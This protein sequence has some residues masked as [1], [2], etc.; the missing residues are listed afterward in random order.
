M[1]LRNTR[2]AKRTPEQQVALAV[3]IIEHRHH[4]DVLARSPDILGDRASMIGPIDLSRNVLRSWTDRV[5]RAYGITPFVGSMSPIL[6]A[7]LGDASASVTVAKYATADGYPMPST[8]IL[9]SEEAQRYELGAGFAGVLI[10]W[11]KRT[12]RIYLEVITPDDLCITYDSDDPTEPTGIIQRG[13][14][15]IAGQAVE[16]EETYDLTDLEQPSYRV[17]KG[18]EDVTQTVHGE[19]FTGEDYPWRYSDGTP[20]HRIV[21]R[22]N[23]KRVYE[24]SRQV[25]ASLIVPV[26]WTAWG[27]GTDHCS[28]PG[29]NVRGMVPMTLD[30]DTDER[31][32]GTVAG[33][34]VVH[35]WVDINPERPG[36]HWQDAPA[37][38]P[39]TTAKAIGFYE[40][41]TLSLI[42]LPIQMEATG[43]EPTAREAEAM[44]EYIRGTFAEARRFDGE[45]LRRC[46]ALANSLSEVDAT[47]LSEEPYGTLYRHE[48][49][50]ALKPAD[51]TEPETDDT[52]TK[53]EDTTDVRDDD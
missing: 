52:D 7:A 24:R 50:D 32:T 34:A 38:D 26:R 27:S 11:S 8:A 19:T 37:F 21:L 42:D 5:G 20:Y 30:S 12:Q 36:D 22:G 18:A 3:R 35:R 17:M 10:G 13:V 2:T 4:M 29:R 45:L 41:L 16:V 48:I 47:D 14:R 33:P 44:E 1:M 28:H 15:T 46:A 51:K 25:E 40:S 43:G 31:Q 23:P 53:T 49:A 9:A 39:L 6:A